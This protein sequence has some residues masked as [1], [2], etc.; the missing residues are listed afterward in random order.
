LEEQSSSGQKCNNNKNNLNCRLPQVSEIVKT[1][2]K[3][4]N[5]P[6]CSSWSTVLKIY[7]DGGSLTLRLPSFFATL[8]VVVTT[9][10]T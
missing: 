10:Y 9:P 8:G 5:Q 4:T 7:R 6:T 3:M 1:K 2:L